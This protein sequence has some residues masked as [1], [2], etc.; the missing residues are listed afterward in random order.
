LREFPYR[1]SKLDQHPAT[2]LYDRRQLVAHRSFEIVAEFTDWVSGT[3][4]KQPDL[5]DLLLIRIEQAFEIALRVLRIDKLDVGLTRS[6]WSLSNLETKRA[7][8]SKR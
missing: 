4:A 8:Y 1:V 3:K 7:G 5:G 2:Q 6:E